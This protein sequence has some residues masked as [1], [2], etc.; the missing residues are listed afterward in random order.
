MASVYTI[1]NLINDHK[2]VGKTE[3]KPEER[4]K[5]H[6]YLSKYDPEKMTISTAINK[7]GKEN[8]KFEVIEECSPEKVN[9]REIFWISKLNTYN[10]GYNS[11]IGGMEM[12]VLPEK[13]E[14]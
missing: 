11:T 7:H 12:L 1:T 14:Q 4:W 8:F 3:R 9:D 10:D 6:I 13:E 2:Y 5:E